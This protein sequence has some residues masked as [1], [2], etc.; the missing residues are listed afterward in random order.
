MVFFQECIGHEIGKEIT[1]NYQI[2]KLLLN[3]K[4]DI[5]IKDIYGNKPIDYTRNKEIIDLF[6][7]S[8][9]Y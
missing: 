1:Y 2:I 8:I 9:F 3:N 5:H 6:S 4:A 7:K